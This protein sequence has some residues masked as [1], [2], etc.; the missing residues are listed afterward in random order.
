MAAP[1]LMPSVLELLTALQA[2]ILFAHLIYLHK[3]S[4]IVIIICGCDPTKLILYMNDAMW[5]QIDLAL[6]AVFI[7]CES[8]GCAL[9]PDATPLGDGETA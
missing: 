8:R 3:I 5:I 1:F 9:G 4:Q 2:K 6:K 7:D